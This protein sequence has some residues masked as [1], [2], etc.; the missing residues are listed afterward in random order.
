LGSEQFL[1]VLLISKIYVQNVI[2]LLYLVEMVA[3]TIMGANQWLLLK[4]IFCKIKQKKGDEYDCVL[5][6]PSIKSLLGHDLNSLEDSGTRQGFFF[7]CLG[8]KNQRVDLH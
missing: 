6:K 5:C 4:F 1:W 3:F 8:I 2:F 7:I